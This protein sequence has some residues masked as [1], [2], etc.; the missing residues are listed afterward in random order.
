MWDI[1][2]LILAY[3]RFGGTLIRENPGKFMESRTIRA[4]VATLFYFNY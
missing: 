1:P 4:D 2:T 3:G